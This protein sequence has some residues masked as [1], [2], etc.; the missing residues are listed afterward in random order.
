MYIW[1]FD[2]HDI[3]T[4]DYKYDPLLCDKS[5]PLNTNQWLIDL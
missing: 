3:H 2:I 4:Q 5:T 1:L